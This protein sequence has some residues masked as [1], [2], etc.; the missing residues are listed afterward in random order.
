VRPRSVCCF[1]GG[2][3]RRWENGA[4]LDVIVDPWNNSMNPSTDSFQKA[5]RKKISVQKMLQEHRWIY[6]I[7]PLQTPQEIQEYVHLWE[8]VNGTRLEKNREDTIR[9][10]WTTDGEYT[11]K[12]AYRVQFEGS[13]MPIWRAGAEPKCRFFRLD[14]SP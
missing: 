1:H 14:T 8:R 2:D 10:R 7:L 5:K 13:F 3:H 6:H 12:S 11:T 9:W 4:V